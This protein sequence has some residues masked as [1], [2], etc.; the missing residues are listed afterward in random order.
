MIIKVAV[1]V[2]AIATTS[3]ATLMI[4]VAAGAAGGK[5]IFLSRKTSWIGPWDDVF[6]D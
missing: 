3:T 6:R 1:E 2:V 4:I 5:N